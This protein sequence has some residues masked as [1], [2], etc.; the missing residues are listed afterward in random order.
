[1]SDFRVEKHHARATLTLSSGVE[2]TGSFFLAEATPHRVGP[3]RVYDLLNRPDRFFPFEVDARED[4]GAYVALFSREH[5]VVAE[6]DRETSLAEDDGT[7]DLASNKI[8]SL[9]LDNGARLRGELHIEMPSGRDRVSDFANRDAR[10]SYFGA[11]DALKLVNLD[12]VAEI[13]P[14]SD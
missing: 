5:V 11:R 1:M 12:R 9:L 14:I 7:F 2:V 10:F 8:V 13:L 6:L 3:E 4:R